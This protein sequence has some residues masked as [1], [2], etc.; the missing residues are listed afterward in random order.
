VSGHAE[1]GN[2]HA[3]LTELQ[4]MARQRGPLRILVDESDLKPGLMG[5][6][7]IFEIVQDWRTSTALRASRIAI[8]APDPIVRGLNQTFRILANLE[9]KDVVNAFS[10]RADALAWLVKKAAVL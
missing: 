7:D 8:I 6:N 5:F 4:A 3:L 2:I 1:P 9:R 10:K